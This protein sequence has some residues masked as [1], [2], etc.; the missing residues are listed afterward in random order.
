MSLTCEL[1]RMGLVTGGKEEARRGT[2]S[3]SRTIAFPSSIWKS[4][5]LVLVVDDTTSGVVAA[6]VVADVETSSNNVLR[7]TTVN[8]RGGEPTLNFYCS[9]EIRTKYLLRQY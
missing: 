1:D 4:Y 2:K 7:S 5:N 6:A 8:R 9:G 3:N